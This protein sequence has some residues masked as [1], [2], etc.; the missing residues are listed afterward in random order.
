M[1]PRCP[2]GTH[3]FRINSTSELLDAQNHIA[4]NL[5]ATQ[6]FRY[7]KSN[8]S[9]NH[10]GTSGK[11]PAGKIFMNTFLCKLS[12]VLQQC[13]AERNLVQ[14]QWAQTQCVK[15]NILQR[16]AELA[17]A[18]AHNLKIIRQVIGPGSIDLVLLE[19]AQRHATTLNSLKEALAAEHERLSKVTERQRQTL[20]K[21]D[22]HVCALEKFRKKKER[23]KWMLELRQEI[24][25]LDEISHRAFQRAN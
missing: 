24:Q 22:R 21:A 19:N 5:S 4:D 8:L 15:E 20:L 13:Q 16:Q 3:F 9:L 18:L 25:Q 17:K 2:P 14:Q 23:I 1:V 11:P 12:R 6:I 7:K 10:S